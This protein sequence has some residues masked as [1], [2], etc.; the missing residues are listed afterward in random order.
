MRRKYKWE[1]WFGRNFMLLVSGVHYNCSQS[2]MV[3]TIRNNASK[4]GLSVQIRDIGTAITVKVIRESETIPN[5]REH[6]QYE[7]TVGA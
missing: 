2:T 6:M 5:V 1:E 7:R 4:R 3:Q